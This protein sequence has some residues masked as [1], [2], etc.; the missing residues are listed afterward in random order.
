[1]FWSRSLR[2]F[3]S[4][5]RS[6]AAH[7][8]TFRGNTLWIITCTAREEISRD[9]FV[10]REI[11]LN[12]NV[13]RQ[14]SFFF[15]IG[16]KNEKRHLFSQWIVISPFNFHVS[17]KLLHF[18]L[19]MCKHFFLEIFSG[20]SYFAFREASNFECA[21]FVNFSFSLSTIRLLDHRP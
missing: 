10:S 4:W 8:R 15:F 19:W 17:L 6:L 3:R 21:L 16:A 1:M 5:L 12:L 7:V 14:R 11:S 9:S 13:V 18:R 20:S 2:V